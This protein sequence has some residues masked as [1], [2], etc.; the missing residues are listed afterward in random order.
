MSAPFIPTHAI[1]RY[2]Q[3]VE[4][5]KRERV[6]KRLIWGYF[7]GELLKTENNGTRHILAKYICADESLK[8]VVLVVS[9]AEDDS[10]KPYV[11]KTVLTLDHYQANNHMAQVQRSRGKKRRDGSTFRFDCDENGDEES[12]IEAFRRKRAYVRENDDDMGT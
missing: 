10:K 9:P 4:T 6:L 5:I 11:M 8:E 1:D 7:N 2:Q 3:I 12:S